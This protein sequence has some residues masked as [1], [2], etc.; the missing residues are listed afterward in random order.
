MAG[1]ASSR[2]PLKRAFITTLKIGLYAFLVGLIA[3]VV[4]VAVAVSQLPTFQELESRNNLGQTVRVHAADGSLLVNLGPSLWRMAALRPDPRGH[5]GR[6][7]LGGG[8]TLSPPYRR[9]SDRHPARARRAGDQGPL[10]AGRLDH[11][12][13]ARP[14]HLPDQQPHVR[15]QD[16][17]GDPRSG[18][19]AALHQGP[20]PRALPQPRLFRRRRLWH[21]RRVAAL[22]RPFGA[23]PEPARG[24]DHRRPGQGAVQLFADR[25]RR[26]CEGS[27][28]PSSSS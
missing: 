6:H 15:P 14:Q 28:R 16:S 19:G 21:R 2:S 27:R 5:E 20:D 24:R 23:H 7:R 18:A 22:L 13:A 11:H 1:N 25:R 12:P 10:E 4:A 3:L 9:R 17:R 26:R 8:Q